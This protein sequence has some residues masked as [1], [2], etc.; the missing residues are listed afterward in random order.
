MLI[1]VTVMCSGML[2]MI[3]LQSDLIVFICY[4]DQTIL[5]IFRH[6]SILGLVT[7]CS[8]MVEDLSSTSLSLGLL[9]G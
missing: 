3:E 7:V 8:T 2:R 6:V 4:I 9:P 1:N 5:H